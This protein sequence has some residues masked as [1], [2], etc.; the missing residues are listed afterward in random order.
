[1]IFSEDKINLLK[2]CLKNEYVW[3]FFILKLLVI[4]IISIKERIPKV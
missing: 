3:L 1:M 4:S 2:K